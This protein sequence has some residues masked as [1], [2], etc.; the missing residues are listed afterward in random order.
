VVY[1]KNLVGFHWD[2]ARTGKDAWLIDEA[3]RQPMRDVIARAIIHAPT[4]IR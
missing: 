1:L 3:D 2:P 4:L